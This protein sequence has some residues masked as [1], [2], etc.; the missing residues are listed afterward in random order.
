[1]NKKLKHEYDLNDFVCT[2]GIMFLRNNNV[3][4]FISN[5]KHYL[6]KDGTVKFYCG[7]E[8]FFNTLEEAEDFLKE[9]IIKNMKFDDFLTEEEMRIE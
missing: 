3:R 9:C 2:K 8:N 6:H 5:G 7:K 1:M 4:Y